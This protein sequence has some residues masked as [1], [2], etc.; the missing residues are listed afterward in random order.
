MRRTAAQARW[1]LA[2]TAR[3]RVRPATEY[4]FDRLMC[5]CRCSSWCSLVSRSFVRVV[6]FGLFAVL[7]ERIAHDEPAL[8]ALVVRARAIANAVENGQ[9]T[10]RQSVRR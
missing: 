5:E 7:V 10:R 9:N 3:R 2:P 6:R 8:Q 1:S 4:R